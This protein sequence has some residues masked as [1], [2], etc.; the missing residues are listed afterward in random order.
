[1]LVDQATSSAAEWLAETVADPERVLA[2]WHD[3]AEHIATL[4]AGIKFDAIRIPLERAERVMGALAEARAP[5]CPLYLD[6]INGHAY[7]LVAPGTAA[8]WNV[9]GTY[10]LGTATWLWVPDPA[11]VGG[12][13]I[14][15]VW[16]PD[17][18][19]QLCPAEQ[20]AQA[21]VAA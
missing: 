3:D 14:S 17:G 9:P 18:S 11:S 16:P 15:W 20:L 1:M 8:T 2:W 5:H 21:L 19:G 12:D 7:V 13:G 6:R 4:P 10:A